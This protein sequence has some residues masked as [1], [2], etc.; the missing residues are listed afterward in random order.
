MSDA[1]HGDK[2]KTNFLWT[3]GLLSQYR[4]GLLFPGARDSRPFFIPEFPAMVMANSR[5]KRECYYRVNLS[6]NY[7]NSVRNEWITECG[8]QNAQCSSLLRLQVGCDHGPTPR[9]IGYKTAHH[10][11]QHTDRHSSS[12]P[13]LPPVTV[14]GPVLCTLHVDKSRDV[15]MSRRGNVA[16]A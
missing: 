10:C 1:V 14:C 2:M 13:H 5:R 3:F 15:P 9:P 11:S 16:A 12:S 6:T 4:V 8:V 7:T